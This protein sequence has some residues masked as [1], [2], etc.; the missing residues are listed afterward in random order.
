MFA[1]DSDRFAVT[2][3]GCYRVPVSGRRTGS[4]NCNWGAGQCRTGMGGRFR[5]GIEPD[6]AGRDRWGN[7][8]PRRFEKAFR[9]FLPIFFYQAKPNGFGGCYGPL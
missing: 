6:T 2:N 5:T 3:P 8:L 1:V 4:G 9:H 7:C